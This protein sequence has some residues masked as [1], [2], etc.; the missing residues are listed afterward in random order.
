MGYPY[1]ML[2]NRILAA[3]L[4]V[5]TLSGCSLLPEQVDKTKGWSASK[6]Y[7]EAKSSL[8]DG[9]YKTAIKYFEGLEARYPFGTYAQQAQLEAAYAYYKYE[10]PDSAISTLDR[11]IK[12]YPR[13][14]NVDYAYYLKGLVNFNRGKGFLDEHMPVDPTKRDPGSARQSFEDFSTLV[15]KFPHSKYTPDARKR[16]I[17]LRNLLAAYEVHVARYYMERGAYVAAA[18][19]TKYVLQNYQH[20][21]AVPKALVVMIQAYRK[22]GLNDLANDA[23]RVLELNFPKDPALAELKKGS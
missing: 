3:L 16:M 21:P 4:I 10:E 7:T 18:N 23:M 17:Y 9:D 20:T 6:F 19:R 13:H 8:D 2:L 15:T 22:L 11:F 14:P 12:T 1:A 5:V